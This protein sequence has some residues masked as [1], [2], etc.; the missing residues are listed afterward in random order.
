MSGAAAWH[1][2]QPH[3]LLSLNISVVAVNRAAPSTFLLTLRLVLL[4]VH[5]LLLLPLL[6]LSCRRGGR[7]PR[8]ARSSRR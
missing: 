6:P 1:Q 8:C 7:C 4:L 5:P 2:G 3:R